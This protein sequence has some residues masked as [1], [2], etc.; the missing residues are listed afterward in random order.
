[1]KAGSNSTILASIMIVVMLPIFFVFSQLR[2]HDYLATQ[3]QI[4]ARATSDAAE[5]VDQFS[6]NS[7]QRDDVSLL[8]FVCPGRE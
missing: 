6:G 5:S 3:T 8:H 4:A 7:R 1:M 2:I